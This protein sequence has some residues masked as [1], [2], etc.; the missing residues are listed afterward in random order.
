MLGLPFGFQQS[1]FAGGIVIMSLV[2]LFSNHCMMIL[3]K[4]KHYAV[5][6][7][8]EIV[9]FGDLARLTYGRPGII[10]VDVLLVFTQVGV[11]CVY[12]VYVSTNLAAIANNIIPFQWFMLVWLPVLILLSWIRSL[13]NVAPLTTIANVLVGSSLVTILVAAIISI[14]NKV[15]SNG[16]M[17]VVW[18][19]NWSGLPTMFGIAVYAFEGIGIVIPAETA[20]T[21]PEIYKKVL[22]TALI[23]ASF[24]YIFFGSMCYVGFGVGTTDQI[25]R[26]MRAFAGDNVAWQVVVKII[27]AFLVG[28]IA[29]SFPLQL[30]VATDVLEEKIF[31]QKLLHL[32]STYWL[33]NVFRAGIVVFAALIAVSVPQFGLLVGLIG[34]SGSAALQ[35]IFPSLIYLKLLWRDTHILLKIVLIFYV[36]FGVGGGAWGTYDTIE[37]IIKTFSNSGTAPVAPTPA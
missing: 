9:T 32:R 21:K 30:F 29:M 25:L 18:G 3:V 23:I 11:C 4:C 37:Q 31:N 15:E 7:G 1:G 10:I 20:I 16:G 19:A 2:A 24:N 35:F 26:N 12:V 14:S 28:T 34:A 22:L 27:T 8:H 6:Q 36:I 13:K 17:D 33:Q 5:Q